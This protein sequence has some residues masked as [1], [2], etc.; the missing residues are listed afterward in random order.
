MLNFLPRIVT[1]TIKRKVIWPVKMA[2]AIIQITMDN[3]RLQIALLTNI[4][5][6]KTWGKRKNKTN[7]KSNSFIAK[8]QSLNFVQLEIAANKAGHVLNLYFYVI[9]IFE[10]FV[11]I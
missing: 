7:A 11:R 8:R 3:A 1:Q 6:C 4:I 5:S 9:L 10:R 2:V